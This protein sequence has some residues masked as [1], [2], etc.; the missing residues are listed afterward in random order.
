VILWCWH[1][2]DK[3]WEA[4]ELPPGCQWRLGHSAVAVFLPGG[5]AVLLAGSGVW[6]NGLPALSLRALAHLDEIRAEGRVVVYS[7]ESRH[8]PAPLPPARDGATCARCKGPLHSGEP[9]VICSVCS[10]P[11]H[12]AC[13][14]FDPKCAACP[15]PT[16]GVLT[17][18]RS[19]S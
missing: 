5:R 13:F 1:D 9:A 3:I 19:I 18:P 2:R 17:F 10:S 6:V 11:H 15:S 16:T 14:T 12:P 7:A 8:E 4:R